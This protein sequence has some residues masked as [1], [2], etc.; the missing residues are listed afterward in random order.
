MSFF[1]KSLVFVLSLELSL[2]FRF[3]LI[4]IDFFKMCLVAFTIFFFPYLQITQSG[5][6]FKMYFFLKNF[7]AA[8]RV[9]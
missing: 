9:V 8:G 4:E 6:E 3:R 5:L 1:L 2:N 7:F